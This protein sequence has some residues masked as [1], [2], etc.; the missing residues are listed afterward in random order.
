MQCD[1]AAQK[2]I[3]RCKNLT[4]YLV[5][6][7]GR[8]KTDYANAPPTCRSQPLAAGV[9]PPAFLLLSNLLSRKFEN[10]LKCPQKKTTPEEWSLWWWIG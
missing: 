4:S 8:C 5:F 10:L 1:V 6:Y 3:C 2:T 9:L 7:S